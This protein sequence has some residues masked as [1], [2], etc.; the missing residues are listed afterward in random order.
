MGRFLANLISYILHPLLMPTLLLLILLY[1]LPQALQPV[2]GRIALLIIL[3]VFITTFIIPVLSIIGL[4]STM[5]IS[6]IKMRNR[7]E[8]V[9]PFT[10]ITIFYA[11]TT[12]LF[13]SKIEINDLIL[14]IFVGATVIVALLTVITLFFKISV[15]AAGAGCMLGFL[16]SIMLIFPEHDLM[17]T[18]IF[19]VLIVGTILSARLYLDAHT[20]VEVYS[21]FS[22]GLFVSFFSVNFLS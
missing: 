8:R 9:L 20:P 7:T 14:A 16:M 4:R 18:L 13:H 17:W 11:L 12:Y 3:L 21:G 22:L 1:F 5:A 15:H 2:S 6:S 10:F 19:I